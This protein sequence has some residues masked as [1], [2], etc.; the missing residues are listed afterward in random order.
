MYRNIPLQTNLH[1]DRQSVQNDVKENSRL[2]N[3]MLDD[4][5]PRSHP[6][7]K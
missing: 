2:S 3:Y 6:V 1:N 7:Y 4:L 5:R